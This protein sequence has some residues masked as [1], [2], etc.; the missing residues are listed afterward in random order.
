MITTT[1][2]LNWQATIAAVI[3]FCYYSRSNY[4]NKGNNSITIKLDL[5]ESGKGEKRGIIV[6]IRGC[7]SS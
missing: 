7:C 6:A 2:S 3:I 1:I 5:I 4:Y